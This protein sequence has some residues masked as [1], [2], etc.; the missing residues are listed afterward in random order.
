MLL[1][2]R[3]DAVDTLNKKRISNSEN[4]LELNK[5]KFFNES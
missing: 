4:K 2:C 3:L 1:K 5:L